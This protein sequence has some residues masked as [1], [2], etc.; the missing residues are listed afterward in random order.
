MELSVAF[1]APME[2]VDTELDKQPTPEIVVLEEESEARVAEWFDG[3]VAVG[4]EVEEI[5][6]IELDLVVELLRM[7][8]SED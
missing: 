5:G 2:F 6:D 7:I 8:L 4:V 3:E 1:D